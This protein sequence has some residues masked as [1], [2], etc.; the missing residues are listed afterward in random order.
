MRQIQVTPQFS[1][2]TG[3]QGHC[4]GKKKKNIFRYPHA[5]V[6]GWNELS[7]H[8]LSVKVW[9]LGRGLGSSKMISFAA[10]SIIHYAQSFKLVEEV[11]L[12]LLS[13]K[14]PLL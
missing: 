4:F 13:P 7:I 5:H 8:V 1:R 9:R 12:K 10:S 11:A 6:D 14:T 2:A 3:L